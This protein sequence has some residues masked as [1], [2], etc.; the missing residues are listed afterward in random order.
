MSRYKW[1]KKR[2]DFLYALGNSQLTRAFFKNQE[3]LIQSKSQFAE[4]TD[5]GLANNGN[6]LKISIVLWMLLLYGRRVALHIIC[7]TVNARMVGGRVREG[8]PLYCLLSG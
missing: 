2:V 1:I 3:R 8:M 7:V 4:I 6:T 5:N